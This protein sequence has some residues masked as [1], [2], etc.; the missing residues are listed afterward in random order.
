[1]RSKGVSIDQLL[2]FFCILSKKG[3]YSN[4]YLLG[5]LLDGADIWIYRSKC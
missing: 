5:R 4:A 3:L 2:P 1:M